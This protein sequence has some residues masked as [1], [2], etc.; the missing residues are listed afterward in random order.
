MS[1]KLMTVLA[2]AG[3]V[4]AACSS[5]PSTE[6]AAQSLCSSLAGLEASI[7]QVAALGADSSVVSM[8][9]IEIAR[10]FFLT[11]RGA[12]HDAPTAIGSWGNVNVNEPPSDTNARPISTRFTCP[13]SLS[14]RPSR[15][16]SNYLGSR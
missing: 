4:I 13:M 2:A 10:Q 15:V 8:E 7:G 5:T 3:L 9:R 11:S 14:R 16:T 1:T 6:E 12:D